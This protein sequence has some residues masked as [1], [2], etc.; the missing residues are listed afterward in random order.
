MAREVAEEAGVALSPHDVHYAMSQPWP[1]SP[2]NPQLMLGCVA[3]AAPHPDTGSLPPLTSTDADV[4]SA[5]GS[6]PPPLDT[7]VSFDTHEL[8][9]AAWFPRA[10]VEAA[11]LKHHAT[12]GVDH[13]DGGGAG[14]Q[15]ASGAPR[16]G[17]ASVPPPAA[18]AHHLLRRAVGLPD[19]A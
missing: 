7:R 15:A 12:S 3:S 17:L 2:I 8:E 4:P 16:A 13:R 19:I 10:V 14:A 18:V 9:H 6:T 1:L 11:L 5:S